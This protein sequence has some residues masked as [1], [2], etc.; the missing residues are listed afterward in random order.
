MSFPRTSLILVVLAGCSEPGLTEIAR[1]NVLASQ[2]KYAD[3]LAAYQAAAAAQPRKAHPQELAG[4]LLFD[5]G[6]SAEARIAYQEAVKREPQDA[7]EA[8]IGLA[9]LDAE[10][11]RFDDAL[12]RLNGILEKNPENLYALLSRAT[13]ALRRGKPGDLEVSLVDTAKAMAIDS[14]GAA[15]LYTRGSAFIVAKDYQQA[16]SAFALLEHAHPRSPLAFYGYARLASAKGDRAAAIANLRQARSRAQDLPGG[17]NP[18]EVR[19]DPAFSKLKDDPEF[20]QIVDSYV[21]R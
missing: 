4:H 19:S 18:R 6:R 16:Q 2:K 11:L 17:W 8:K 21:S 15:V 10:D 3:A 9:R 1:G 12:E 14:N 5:L 7:L 20:A 13:V